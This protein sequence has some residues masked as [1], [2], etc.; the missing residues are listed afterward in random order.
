M[1]LYLWFSQKK[2]LALSSETTLPCFLITHSLSRVE[3]IQ[4][5]TEVYSI[6]RPCLEMPG[7]G[8]SDCHPHPA[9]GARRPGAECCEHWGNL[10][11]SCLSQHRPVW[12]GASRRM[13]D[14]VQL[15]YCFV[16]PMS[17]TEP[18]LFQQ[19]KEIRQHTCQRPKNTNP[20]TDDEH[21]DNDKKNQKVFEG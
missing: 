18:S 3:G 9:A 14:S 1:S 17:D 2:L 8:S 16:K 20:Q 6:V 7:P 19:M 11:M 4:G 12:P 5:P 15:L 13:S 10:A 21:A